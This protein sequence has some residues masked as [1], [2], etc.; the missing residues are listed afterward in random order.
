MTT[1]TMI[2]NLALFILAFLL[3][4]STLQAGPPDKKGKSGKAK[5]EQ[6]SDD[7]DFDIDID[8]SAL[9]SAGISRG[10]ARKLASQHGLTGSKPLPP[11]IRK[12]MARGKPMPP[13]I[14]KTQNGAFL[15]IIKIA[16]IAGTGHE[17]VADLRPGM[18]CQL[19]H[20]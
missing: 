1:H 7:D 3:T 16:G 8:L 10:D 4:A 9:A 13:G 19:L 15:R 11:G 12:N 6:R 20:D 14:Q 17:A 18:P 5:N 2:R